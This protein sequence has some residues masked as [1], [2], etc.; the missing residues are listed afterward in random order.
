M[1]EMQEIKDIEQSTSDDENNSFINKDTNKTKEKDKQINEKDNSFITKDSKEIS[2]KN[3]NTD[4]N[5]IFNEIDSNSPLINN[6]TPNRF[7]GLKLYLNNDVCFQF[8][9]MT[10]IGKSTAF[11]YNKNDDPLLIIGPQ[12]PYCLAMLLGI[13]LIYIFI[14][15][16]YN[17]NSSTFVKIFDWIFYI[18]W[19]I[20]YIFT[21]IKNPGYPK[22]CSDTIK[23]TKEMLYCEKCELWYKPTSSTIHCE[24]C[25]ICIEGFTHHCIWFGHCIGINNKK[26]FY[27]FLIIS[28]LF[29]VYLISN[30][31]LSGR[32]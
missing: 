27:F 25:D 16:Y 14:Y 29:P 19:N 9:K 17:K 6:K 3:E 32:N 2:L 30:I 15:Y 20:S 21:S 1:K 28:F 18:L 31:I 10:K 23:G 7:F 12:W 13:S 26:E 5:N 8:L 11:F 22:M 4:D 24:I